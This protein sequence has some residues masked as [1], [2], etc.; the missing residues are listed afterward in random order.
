MPKAFDT[1]QDELFQNA[2]LQIREKELKGKS[3]DKIKDY[4]GY[5]F[6]TLRNVFMDKKRRLK[7]RTLPI[8][9]QMIAGLID[10]QADQ[11]Q[12]CEADLIEWMFEDTRNEN[13]KFYKNILILQTKVKVHKQVQEQT[14]M[15]RKTYLNA[16][17]EA[18]KKAKDEIITRITDFN[19][20]NH[21]S[22]V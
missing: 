12:P 18:A 4:K 21:V 9:E 8:N 7:I 5:F 3:F 20:R 15:D 22:L 2:W 17:K 14:T 1:D 16:R 10:E 13:D 11:L 6:M 19:K